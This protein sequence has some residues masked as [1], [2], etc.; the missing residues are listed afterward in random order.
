MDRTD[1]AYA[2][3]RDGARPAEA[4]SGSLALPV[5]GCP[6][7]TVADLVRHTS[8]VHRFWA[9]IASREPADPSGYALAVDGV[10]ELPA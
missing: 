4:A 2:L 3:R 1:H 8:S 7:W 9:A 5:P 6:E 10:D